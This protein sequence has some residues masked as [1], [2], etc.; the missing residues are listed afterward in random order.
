MPRI[1]LT[2]RVIARLKGRPA[3]SKSLEPVIYFDVALPGFGVAVSTKTGLKT[4]VVQRDLPDGRTVRRTIGR[5]GTEIKTLE[6]ARAQAA[7]IIHG[8]R[9]GID[10]KATAK[11]SVT[12]KQAAEAYLIARPNL[13]ASSVRGYRRAFEKYLSEWADWK[14][15]EITRE[16]VEAR[17]LELAEQT[18]DPS[19]A[20]STMRALR[21]VFNFAVDRFP[22][23]TANPVRLKGQWFKVL[24]RE[25][26][27]SADDL[28]KFY[29]AVMK[30]E[31]P[32]ARDYLLLLLFS[33]LRREEAAS[34]TWADVDFAAKIIRLP[35]LRTKAKRK[36]DLPMSDFIFQLLQKRRTLGDANFVFPA[37]AASGHIAEPRHFLA[38]IEEATGIVAS[39]HSLRRTFATAADA[40]GVN[41]PVIAAMLNHA[42]GSGV[43]P[44]YIIKSAE[45][46]TEPV[47]KTADQLKKW[48]KIKY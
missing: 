26:H 28:P 30:L 43:T 18:G 24:S 33:G 2:E 14:L 39:P 42:Q 35:A 7:D 34:L 20:N 1:K 3:G 8:L 48:C 19:T 41:E 25:D 38:T 46:L 12:L 13:A 37:H 40:A 36:L 5:V 16:K 17:H 4:Y 10:P 15:T 29:A 9:H 31:N 11:G 22:D 32:V 27:V 45:G 21:A 23:V 47:Q 44:R 6:E